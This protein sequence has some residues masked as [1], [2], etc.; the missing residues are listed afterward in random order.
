MQSTEEKLNA[1]SVNPS[2]EFVDKTF[3]EDAH[4]R[5][6]KVLV[7]TVNHPE[8]ISRMY[9]LGV[10]GVFTNYPDRFNLIL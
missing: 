6:L 1:Y 4:N 3:V 9:N 10:D 7:Y 8:D 5:G 2:I